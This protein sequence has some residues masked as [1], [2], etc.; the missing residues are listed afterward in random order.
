M[1]PLDIHSS[2]L[3]M[4]AI[5][6][7]KDFVLLIMQPLKTN[8]CLLSE[9]NIKCLDSCTEVVRMKFPICLDGLCVLLWMKDWGA[10]I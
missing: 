4:V 6:S 8:T 2:D 1:P 10:L 5:N 9:V 3:K 7:Y